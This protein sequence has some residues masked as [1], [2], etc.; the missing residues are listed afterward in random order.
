M[1][2]AWDLPQFHRIF[3]EWKLDTEKN[4]CSRYTQQSSEKRS[5]GVFSLLQSVELFV[6][7]D[8]RLQNGHRVCTLKT[9]CVVR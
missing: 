9:N 2:V 3:E 6:D 8:E 4:D 1:R 5:T 7:I